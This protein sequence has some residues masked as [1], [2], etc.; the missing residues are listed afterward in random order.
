MNDLDSDEK[1]FSKIG[2]NY[3]IFAILSIAI[4]IVIVSIIAKTDY[5]LL[6]DFNFL[7]IITSICNYILPF[8]VFYY[9]MKKLDT[10]E[11]EKSKASS[12][13][14]I[15]YIGI[16]F[17]LMI[18]G[19]IIGLA[20]TSLLGGFIEGDIANP[21]E[22]LINSTNIWLNLMLISIIG[23]VFEEI[24]F[25]KLL[26][27]RTIKYGARISII[28]SALI[29]GFYH[30][31]LN[32]F[33]YTF[34]LGGIFSYIYIK[35][36]NIIYPIILHILVNFMGSV[37]SLSVVNST[38]LIIDG[39]GTIFDISFILIYVIIFILAI[40]IGILGLLN[41]KKAKFNG[42][43]TLVNLKQ[44]LRTMILNPGMLIF[45]TFFIVEI[46]MQAI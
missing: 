10:Y 4:Q 25:R 31:N 28:L 15:T 3:L 8:P 34:L 21:V 30:G 9:L 29:F 40:L 44:P 27:D 37:V 11:I 22:N 5:N 33:F 12:K 45:L 19:N 39:T 41:F 7:V 2:L 16:T 1:F 17:T 32:Q 42:S 43:K 18:V 35:T 23:P 46:V 36:G 26:I 38:Q 24:I 20:I 6:N 13:S 14:F